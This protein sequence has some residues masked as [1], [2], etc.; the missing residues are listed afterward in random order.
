MKRR[1]VFAPVLLLAAVVA[2]SGLSGCAALNTVHADLSTWGD[3]PTGRAPGS[4]AFDRLPSQQSDPA[5]ADR[6][7]AVARDALAKA[8]FRPVTVDEKPDVLVQVA[9]RT[10][11]TSADP[12]DDPLWWRGGFGIVGHRWAGT[13]WVIDTRFDRSRY[14]RQVAVLLRD[15]ATGKPLYEARAAN[16]GSTA[17][18]D[19][20]LGALFSAALIDFPRNGPNPRPV[21]VSLP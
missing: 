10:T 21:R 4:Y 2:A 11:R 20:L 14:E 3:W 16:E 17:G 18:G 12:W 5:E 19:A 15:A 9:S 1:T 8:G 7:E 13:V 6:V